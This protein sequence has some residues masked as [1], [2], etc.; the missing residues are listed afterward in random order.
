MEL[1]KVETEKKRAERAQGKKK[2]SQTAQIGEVWMC[3]VCLM[4]PSAFLFELHLHA[5]S[6]L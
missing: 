6:S 2:N 5:S 3:L 4:S 1:R